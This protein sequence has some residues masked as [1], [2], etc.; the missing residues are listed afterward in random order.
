MTKTI[1][2]AL[3]GAM[4]AFGPTGAAMGSE[5]DA[6][7]DGARKINLH[8]RQAMLVQRMAQTACLAAAGVEVEAQRTALADARERFDHTLR[9]LRTGDEAQGLLLPE[10]DEEIMVQLNAVSR[11]W[12][13]YERAVEDAMAAPEI[14]REQVAALAELTPPVLEGTERAAD[15]ATTVY[16]PAGIAFHV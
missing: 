1:L 6:V 15:R 12:R 5:R 10:R 4:I 7:A 16:V 11:P 2:A 9:S 14:T 8:G 13:E 3:V